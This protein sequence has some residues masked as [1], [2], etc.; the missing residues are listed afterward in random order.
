MTKD[1]IKQQQMPNTKFQKLVNNRFLFRLYLL[2][3]LPMAYI[4]GIRV[5]ELTKEKAIALAKKIEVIYT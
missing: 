5:I 1:I 2:K 4:A 3:S